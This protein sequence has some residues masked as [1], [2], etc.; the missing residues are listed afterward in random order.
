MELKTQDNGVTTV[1]KNKYK[2]WSYKE[3]A[4]RMLQR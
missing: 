3:K 1:E 2:V 4:S